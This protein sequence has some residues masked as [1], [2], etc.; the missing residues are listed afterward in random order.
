MK[1]KLGENEMVLSLISRKRAESAVPLVDC[2]G[3]KFNKDEREDLIRTVIDGA[4]IQRDMDFEEMLRRYD[5]VEF[6]RLK[7]KYEWK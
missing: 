3:R 7:K 4:E 6:N 2:A 1:R 5:T